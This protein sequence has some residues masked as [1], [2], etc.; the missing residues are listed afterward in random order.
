M[1]ARIDGF[2]YAHGQPV[3]RVRISGGG[4]SAAVITYGASL[5]DLR[6]EGH[7]APLVLGFS[8]AEDYVAHSLFFG[9]IVGRCANRIANGRFT[10]DGERFQLET[11]EPT[12]HALH[13]GAEGLWNRVW[14]IRD[15]GTDFVTLACREPDGH[16][17]YPG[18]LDIACTYRITGA[19]TLEILLEAESDAPTLC[20][21]A[22]H[23]WFNL[24]DGGA[25]DVLGHRLMIPSAAY[26]PVDEAL[27]PTGAV[28]PVDGTPFGFRRARTIGAPAGVERIDYDHNY[29]LASARRPRAQAAWAQGGRSGVEMELWTTEPGLQFYAGRM[30]PRTVP[31]LD[32]IAYRAHSGFCLEPQVWPDSPNRPYFP[33]AVLRPGESYRQQTQLRFRLT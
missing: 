22:H 1:A 21:L 2:G 14:Q 26:L 4:L 24:D 12:G 33:Q 10:L 8:R 19:G 23:S 11:N 3:E 20:N 27:I 31:G 17:G 6:I 25:G 9:A 30:P 32:G 18:N 7:V 15:V 5:Q 13:G 28:M 16:M 29:C